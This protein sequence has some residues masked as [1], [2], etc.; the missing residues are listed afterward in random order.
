MTKHKY[1]CLLNNSKKK[2][3]RLDNDSFYILLPVTDENN[4]LTNLQSKYTKQK[5]HGL[6]C[7][8]RK[9]F[10]ILT[11]PNNSTIFLALWYIF[12]DNQWKFIVNGRIVPI[13]VL[14]RILCAEAHHLSKPASHLLKVVLWHICLKLIKM[15]WNLKKNTIRYNFSKLRGRP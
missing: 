7:S 3:H 2:T 5:G 1:K 10:L 15:F 6:H 13:S 14:K 9:Q 11:I 8:F 12:K 4:L